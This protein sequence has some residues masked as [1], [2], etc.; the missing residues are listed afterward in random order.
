MGER[1]ALLHEVVADETEVVALGKDSGFVLQ[2]AVLEMESQATGNAVAVGDLGEIA[3][4]EGRAVERA[5]QQ[6]TMNN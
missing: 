3:F 1:W 2:R 5:E 4:R 6:K